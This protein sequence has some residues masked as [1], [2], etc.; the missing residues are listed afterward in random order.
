VPI[1]VKID[2]DFVSVATFRPAAAREMMAASWSRSTDCSIGLHVA[3][4]QN[5]CH[6]HDAV[7]RVHSAND[8][9]M[10]STSW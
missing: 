9:E 8:S 3:A 10:A 2:Q 4:D 6:E 1:L 5:S 7:T